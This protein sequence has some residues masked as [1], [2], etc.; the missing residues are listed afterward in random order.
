MIHLK[1]PTIQKNRSG[2]VSIELTEAGTWESFPAF[3]EAFA[4]HIGAVLIEEI[5]GPES[6][7][8]KIEIKHIYLNL[9]YDNFPNEIRLDSHS[10]KGDKLLNSLY[11]KIFRESRPKGI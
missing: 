6:R 5:V 1:S 8:W 3:A 7:F 10:D 9:V 4:K 11:K 2:H